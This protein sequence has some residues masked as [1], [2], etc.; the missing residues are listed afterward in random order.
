MSDEPED[1]LTS[2]LIRQEKEISQLKTANAIYSDALKF[3][4][5]FISQIIESLPE[6]IILRDIASQIDDKL[7]IDYLTEQARLI[8]LYKSTLEKTKKELQ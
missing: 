3:C 7:Y 5:A 2:R 4:D 1:L 6:P 8:D